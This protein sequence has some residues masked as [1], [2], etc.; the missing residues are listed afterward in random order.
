MLVQ[1]RRKIRGTALQHIDGRR[2]CLAIVR[3]MPSGVVLT[4]CVIDVMMVASYVL[5]SISYL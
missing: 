5:Y 3:S 2:H 4:N 1:I